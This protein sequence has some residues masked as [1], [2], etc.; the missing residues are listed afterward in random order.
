MKRL[1]VDTPATAPAVEG[2]SH[3]LVSAA[4]SPSPRYELRFDRPA[5][6]SEETLL[7]GNG[8]VGASLFGGVVAERIFFESGLR[9]RASDS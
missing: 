1:P 9:S 2:L 3:P 5:E 4:Q 6:Y 8:R 7:L